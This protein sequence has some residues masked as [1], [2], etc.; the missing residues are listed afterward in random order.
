M[1]TIV[2]KL[3]QRMKKYEELFDA[4]PSVLLLTPEELDQLFATAESKE[5]LISDLATLGMK[6]QLIM[7]EEI[8]NILEVLTIEQLTLLL[9]HPDAKTRALAQQEVRTRQATS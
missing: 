5:K 9:V 3:Y 1:T 4:A 7:P 6:A 2:D 8:S